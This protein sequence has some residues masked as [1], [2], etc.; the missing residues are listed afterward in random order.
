M[1]IRRILMLASLCWLLFAA[2]AARADDCSAAATD[3]VFGAVSPI[4]GSDYYATGT[5]TVTC[6]WNFSGGTVLGTSAVVLPNAS[7]CV[8]LGL[9]SPSSGGARA[10]GYGGALLP[11]ELYRD[12]TYASGSVWG[13][14]PGM[15][16]ATKPATT[17]FVA[18]LALSVQ[19]TTFPVY[20]RIPASTLAGQS[21]SGAGAPYTASFAGAGSI[22]YNFSTL[23]GASCTGGKTASFSFQV[24]ANVIND[25]QISANSLSFGTQGMLSGA[26]RGST[27]L[28]AKCTAGT[29][30]Q[31]ALGAGTVGNLAGGRKMLNVATGET[32][33]YSLS[34]TLDGQPWGDG[35]SATDI[36]SGVGTGAAQSVT[37]YGVVPKQKTPSPGTYADRVTA[38]IVF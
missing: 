1:T 15:P 33:S 38:T 9:G 30:Y 24:T 17:T 18:L 3:I 11:Y 20:A 27:T 28:S 5:I 6:Y 14:G 13:G 36:L 10:M 22:S 26:A 23:I 16:A 4:A 21:A 29:P 37:V 31:I 32:V 19:T 12:S 25:C 34:R 7:V 8:N 35:S 2:P